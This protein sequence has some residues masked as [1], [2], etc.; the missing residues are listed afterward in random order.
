LTISAAGDNNVVHIIEVRTNLCFSHT[1]DVIYYYFHMYVIVPLTS[2]VTN[3]ST[4][5]NDVV[6]IVD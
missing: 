1:P 6:D 2:T 4:N 5:D 3:K